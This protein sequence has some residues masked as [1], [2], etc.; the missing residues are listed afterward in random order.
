M[1]YI[2][3]YIILVRSILIFNLINFKSTDITTLLGL[4]SVLLT[5]NM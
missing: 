4:F 5:K 1:L 2:R 3:I